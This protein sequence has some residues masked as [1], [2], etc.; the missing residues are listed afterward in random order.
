MATDGIHSGFTAGLAI[1]H[2]PQEIAESILARSS[3]G[4]D[5]AHVVVA[6]YLGARA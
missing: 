6:R 5:D 1:E 2:G 3:R 4:T